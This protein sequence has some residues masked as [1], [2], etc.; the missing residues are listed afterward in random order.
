VLLSRLLPLALVFGAGITHPLVAQ[1]AKPFT[2]ERV[3][4]HQYEDGPPVIENYVWMPGETVYLSF[5]ISGY[6]GG[7]G[8]KIALSYKIDAVDP[9]GVKLIETFTGKVDA[10]L[11][12]ED[13]DWLPKV[14]G[15]IPVPPLADTGDYKILISAKDELSGASSEKELSFHVRGREV[16]PSDRLVVRNFRFLRAEEDKAPMVDAVFHP[17]DPV[18]ARFEI[19]GYKLGENN[20]YDVEYG[21]S[22]LKPSGEAI[23]SQPQAAVEQNKSF[24]PKRYVLGVLNLNTRPD[25]KPGEYTIL[26]TVKD[27]VGGQSNE[28]KYSFRIE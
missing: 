17:G 16:E 6:K 24:Y 20:R 22:V 25:T 27:N 9:K 21:L 3:A 11:A 19:T 23:Y 13:K 12:R 15:A 8:D 10:E 18:W 26:L 2:L 1:Q 7:P 4:L 5:L 28:S 14:R